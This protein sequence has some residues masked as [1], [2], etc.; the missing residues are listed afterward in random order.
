MNPYAAVMESA[1]LETDGVGLVG[2]LSRE[3]RLSLEQAAECIERED[4]FGR[5][6]RVSMALSILGELS[7]SLNESASPELSDRLKEVYGYLT[8]EILEVNGR[9]AVG[10]FA[11]CIAV[12][13]TLEEAWAGIQGPTAEDLWGGP[14]SVETADFSQLSICA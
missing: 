8:R 1:A 3:L 5:A 13:R 10:G 2:L 7:Q 12:V 9:P 4:H 11:P 6:K 14:G